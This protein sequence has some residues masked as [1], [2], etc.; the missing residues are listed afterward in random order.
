MESTEEKTFEIEIVVNDEQ[1]E[2]VTK[3]LESN[4]QVIA[5]PGTG[6][7]RRK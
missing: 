3:P 4:V 2:A 7:L 5:G 1:L 6:I